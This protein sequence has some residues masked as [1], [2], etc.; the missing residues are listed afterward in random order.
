MFPAPTTSAISTPRF[1]TPCTW[2]AMRSTRSGS[3]P[4][5]RPPIRASPDSFSS[6]RLN[7]GS[8]ATA[9]TSYALFPDHK[10]GEARDPHV[11]AGLRR[12]IVRLAL[13]AGLRLE[14]PALGLPCLLG[15]LLRRDDQRRRRSARDVNRDL[16]RELLELVAAGDEVRLALDLHQHAHL[17]GR[18]DVGR[19]DALGG[20]SSASLGGRRLAL[21]AQ[22]L[23]RLVD[24]A[25]RLPEG[26]LAVHDPGAGAVPELLDIR[27][28]DVVAVGTHE[29]GSWPAS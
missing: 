3:V 28:L 10:P 18:V 29:L 11:L 2:P 8:S 25:P 19:H 20:G 13:L 22:D 26:G 7:A 17:P 6:T 5:S 9:R 24:I 4:Y 12:D 23:D 14:Q 21:H 15:D 1:A 16:A 27:R